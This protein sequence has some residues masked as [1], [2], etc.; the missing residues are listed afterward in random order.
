MGG[1]TLAA[2]INGSTGGA[3]AGVYDATSAG[4]G[5]VI[6]PTGA[7]GVT[8]E[9]WGAGGGGGY[10]YFGELA[11]GEPE[12]FPGGG[13]GGG[14]YA[15]TVLALVVADAL[16]TINFTVGSGGAGGT[17][18]S[19]FGNPGTFSNVYSGTFTITTMTSN[20]GNGGNS[21]QFAN[22]GAGGTAS[23]GNTVPGTTGNGGAFYTQA[24]AAGISGVGS[25]TAGGGGNGGEFF[26]GEA[27]LNGRV[28]MV[29]TF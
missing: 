11:P 5:S 8:I 15:R 27:G 28:R 20:G 24:G 1:A 9:C 17:A 6:I 23:G 25:L 13:G 10:G 18:F 12:I 26:D 3:G 21:G 29:F 4:S 19:T 7:T 22:Q 2:F 16:K 14:G